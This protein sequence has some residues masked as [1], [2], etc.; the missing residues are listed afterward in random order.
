LRS[1]ILTRKPARARRGGWD[2]IL[3]FVQVPCYVLFLVAVSCAPTNGVLNSSYKVATVSTWPPGASMQA[4]FSGI[5]GGQVN[6]DGTACFW[7]GNGQSRTVLIWPGGY[8]GRGT[9]PSIVDQR[10]QIL[11]SV[12][13]H[14]TLGGGTITP[15]TS[16]ILGCPPAAEA[17]EVGEVV[18]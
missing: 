7:L 5:L 10:G 3:G 16:Y 4:E 18:Q 2:R 14:V 12:G 15:V 6:H 11:A 17:F 8:S 1:V 9:P 13:Q